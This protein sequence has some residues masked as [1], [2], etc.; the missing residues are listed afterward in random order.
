MEICNSNQTGNTSTQHR[1]IAVLQLW[2]GTGTE[3]RQ[4]LKNKTNLKQINMPF[5]GSRKPTQ[6][7][8]LQ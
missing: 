3:V 2:S 4:R 1:A 6:E 7:G 8:L 5:L